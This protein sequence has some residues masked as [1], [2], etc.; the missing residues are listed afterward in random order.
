ML[1][2]LFVHE[3]RDCWRMLTLLNIVVLL[4]TV[5]GVATFRSDIWKTANKNELV[6]IALSSYMMFYIA[7]VF[8]LGLASGVY[9]WFR[10]YRNLYTDQ[11]YL[12]HT[13]PVNAHQ[14]IWS[15]AFVAIIWQFIC[16]S[17][18]IVSIVALITSNADLAAEDFVEMFREI[19]LDGWGVM[20]ILLVILLMLA[21]SFMGIFMG[22]ASVSLGQLVKKHRLGASIGA[23]I[24]LYMMIQM[25]S[26]YGSLLIPAYV[27]K[28]GTASQVE[29]M[30][31]TFL[32]VMLV[33]ILALAA[34]M[35]CI[36]HYIMA[37][38]LNLE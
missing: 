23:Y 6:A 21:S 16:T 5:I 15:K 11:G 30:V 34:L 10:F 32:A 27:N 37:N 7:A 19:H 35:Y 36:T 14:L 38:K 22:Y 1:K 3:W 28:I 4:L 20:I 12:M 33:I 25:A 2:K 18:T 8:A 31:C 26:S 29:T 24:I 13:L 9:F 17:V